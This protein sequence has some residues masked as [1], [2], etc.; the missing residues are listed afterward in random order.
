[1]RFSSAVALAAGLFA[2]GVAGE[3]RAQLAA[4]ETP[5]LRLVYVNPTMA[6]VTPHAGRC[7]QNGLGFE[8]KLF[9]YQ[10]SEKVTVLLTD[11]SDSGNAGAGAV[12]RYNMSLEIAPLSFTYETIVAN[13]RVNFLVNHELVHVMA[14]DKAAGADRFFRSAFAGK[15]APVAEQPESI[16]YFFLTTPRAAAPRWY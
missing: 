11:L 1:M 12:P 4:L 7:F 15:V 3:A 14:M 2:L 13:E 9:D 10:P 8:R 5:D 16:L 6:F